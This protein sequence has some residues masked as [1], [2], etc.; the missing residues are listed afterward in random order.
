MYTIQSQGLRWGIT[1]LMSDNRLREGERLELI[2]QATLMHLDNM[3]KARVIGKRYEGVMHNT[4]EYQTL[5]T[6]G[7]RYFHAE[8]E[9]KSGAKMK[10]RFLVAEPIDP[11]RN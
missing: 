10:V 3:E 6:L 2:V 9:R 4:G 5:G 11:E 8:L 1:F 7:G